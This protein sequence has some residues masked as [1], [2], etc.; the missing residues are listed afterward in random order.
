MN[1]SVIVTGASGGIGSAISQLFAD[2][3]FDVVGL[4]R[5]PSRWTSG[6]VF[7]LEDSVARS[8]L[9]EQIDHGGLSC[10]VHAAAEQMMG[11]LEYLEAEV[12]NRTMWTNVLVL[13]HLVRTFADS[14]RANQGSVVLVGS[15]HALASR[16]MIGSYSVS[17]AAA[18][19][20]VR[21]AALDYAPD[22]RVN[23]VMP[24][25]IDSGKLTEYLDTAGPQRDSVV[26][27]IER[28]TPLMRLGR[29]EDIAQAVGFLAS[30]AASFI[31]GQSIVVDGGATRMLATEVD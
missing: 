29:P 4:D 25:A 9:S 13:D 15:V 5:V 2:R 18:E 24:G 11:H 19:G 23:S 17:K 1:A 7:D 21:A 26:S 22:I 6:S 20:W 12:W 8:A 31:T 27:K 28:R 16:P 10:I 3:G 30:D 14:L